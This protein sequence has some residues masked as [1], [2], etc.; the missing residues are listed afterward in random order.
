VSES[1][2][3]R[4]YSFTAI[5]RGLTGLGLVEQETSLVITNLASFAWCKKKIYMGG[6]CTIVLLYTVAIKCVLFCTLLN[7]S[8]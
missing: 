3:H 1:A 6:F 5:L 7:T 2:R 4:L 8:S